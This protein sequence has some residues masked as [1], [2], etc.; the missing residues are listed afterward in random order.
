MLPILACPQERSADESKA[1]EHSRGR[2]MRKRKPARDE[3]MFKIEPRQQSTGQVVIVGKASRKHA[4]T[5]VNT[6]ISE[7]LRKRLDKQIVGSLAMGTGALLEWALDELE[8]QGIR[9]EAHPKE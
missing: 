5:F 2:A 7:Q 8:R 4:M 9:L 3:R 6:P 1:P